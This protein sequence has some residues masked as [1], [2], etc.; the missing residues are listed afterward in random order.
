MCTLLH[1]SICI[2]Q[3][4]KRQETDTHT[5]THTHI[6]KAVCEHEDWNEGVQRGIEVMDDR[7]DIVIKNKTKQTRQTIDRRSNRM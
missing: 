5:H 6:P 1:Y 4:S 2:H 7:P 3:T